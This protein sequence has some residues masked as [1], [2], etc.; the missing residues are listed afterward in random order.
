MNIFLD[1]QATK[2]VA[3]EAD[4]AILSTFT[5]HHELLWVQHVTTCEKA[6]AGSSM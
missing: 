5:T 2:D 3:I 6:T 1:V 4:I